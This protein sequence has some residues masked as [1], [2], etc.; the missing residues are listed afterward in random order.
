MD[1]GIPYCHT[2]CPVNNQIPDW[3][4]LVYN[5]RL[6]RGF[7]QPA[8]DQQFSGIHRPHLP[9]A[10]RGVVHAQNRR[11]SG[12]HQD[13]SNAP[14]S[15]GPGA[16]L[17]Q[18]GDAVEKT[19]KKVAVVGRRPL[20]SGGGA[21]TGAR[22]AHCPSCSKRIARPAGCM[23]YGIPDFKMEKHHR[24]PP[25]DADGG[26]RRDLPHGA[27][28]RHAGRPA[29]ADSFDAILLTGGAEKPRDLP[30][31]GR[32]FYGVH[33][34]MDFL[35]QQNRRVSKESPL[36]NRPILAGGKHVVVIGGGDTGSDCI[37]TSLRQGALSVT[38]SKSCRG[39]LK[40]KTSRW[41]GPT[42]R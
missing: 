4:D 22:R 3:N 13:P 23:R 30:I 38:H 21:A 9:G 31:P 37:G 20:R 14:S 24:R 18:A 7:A 17:D 32:E 35:P 15:T 26:G 41:S 1:C 8:L 11:Q 5:N 28:R 19:G 6:G 29:T 16:G 25:R 40:R 39:R 10:V 33:L 42:G 12:D 36:D 2:G 34:A 27:H